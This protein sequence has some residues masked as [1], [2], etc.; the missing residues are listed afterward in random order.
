MRSTR[1]RAAPARRRPRRRRRSRRR[2]ARRWRAHARGPPYPAARRLYPRRVPE[3]SDHSGEIDGLPVFW[4]SAPRAR[5]QRRRRCTCTACP[6]NSD[7]WLAFLA[8]T[9]R[10]RARPARLRALGQAGLAAATRSTSTTASSS[11]SSTSVGVERVQPRRAR[12][13]RRRPGLRPAPARA[14]RATRGD[15]RRAA[16]CPATAGTARRAS[17]ARPLLGEL[18][19]GAHHAAARCGCSRA[20]PTRRPGR[21]PRRGSTACSTTS[22]RARS[23]RSC[24]STA[25][26]RRTCSRRPARGSAQLAM[27][28]LVAVGRRRTRTSPRASRGEYAAAL[29]RRRAAGAA[30]TPATGRGSTAPSSIERVV[31][32]LSGGVSAAARERAGAHGPRSPLG[33]PPP[34]WALTAALGARVRDRRAAQ[35][36]PGGGELPQ[37]PVLARGLHAVGQL[38]VRRPPPARLLAARARRSARCSGRSCWRRSR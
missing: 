25:A 33:A 6:T 16:S 24:A 19:M 29:P 7:D 27:P 5:G 2:P 38:L 26:R 28:A 13:G 11:A 4:R 20:R 23:A 17:G 3:V 37:R 18:A 21:C 8:R 35:P 22:T 14:R 12:L 31:D 30:R 36:R 15:Q 10:P 34:A 1:A 9:R 32:F